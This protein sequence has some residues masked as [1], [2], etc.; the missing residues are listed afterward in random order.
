MEFFADK[1]GEDDYSLIR[2]K[3]KF[4]PKKNRNNHLE[5]YIDNISKFP[6]QANQ[7]V[8]QNISKAEKLALKRLQDD[9]SIIIKQADKGGAIVIMDSDYYR[10]L[11][12]DQLSDTSFYSE[13]PENID[14]RIMRRLNNLV[15]RYEHSLTEKEAD[16]LVNFSHKTSNF[17]GL[18]KI[19]KS[20]QIQSAVNLQGTEYIK[21]NPP[22]DLKL[23]P[24]IAG[25]VCPTHR[26]SN[27]ID[28]VLKPLCAYV[29]SFI[30]DDIDFLS[31]VPDRTDPNSLL[32]SYD[33]T[34]L[35]TNIP[36]DLGIEAIKFWIEK[37][38]EAVSDRFDNDFIL[39]SVRFILENN[40]FFF[41]G[42]NYLQIKGTAMGTK[43]APTYATLVMGYLEQKLY[44]TMEQKYGIQ[45]TRDFEK[46]WKRFLDDCFIIWT[47]GN[48]LL[49]ELTEM[50]NNLHPSI[51]FT[52]EVS[53][54]TL[55]FLDISVQLKDEKL[56]TDI[57]Y[58][59]TD[60]HQY[61][62]FKS[63]HPSHTKRNIPYCLARK[64]CTVIEDPILRDE[65]LEELSQFLLKQKYPQNI[66]QH[67]IERAKQ[68]PIESLR[69]TR[70]RAP[71]S[72][73]NDDIIPF[74]VTHNPCNPNIFNIAKANLPILTQSEKLKD[75]ITPNTLIQ[76]KRQP[77][78]LK[79]L[80]TKARFD[81]QGDDKTVVSPCKD[82]RCGTCKYIHSGHE[83]T[84]KDG[85]KI[86]T[87]ANMDCKS[88][89]LIYCIKCPNCK[90]IYIG[91]TGN[92]L[93]ERMRVHRQQV[94]DAAYRQIPLS[95]HIETCGG[96]NF[97]IFP[98]YK[99]KS[100]RDTL[101]DLKER[102]F[103]RKFKPIL[104]GR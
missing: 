6:L 15:S 91:Q 5:Q 24:I 22:T 48:D 59:N 60:T 8:R 39:E 38:R 102:N 40:S 64:I 85:T 79:R 37:H 69:T 3:S 89:N 14:S 100:Q 75:L 94:R 90:E 32:V 103:I 76:S 27:L 87:N 12:E 10:G 74:V 65:R 81:P 99:M 83:I 9:K 80:L 53:N 33:V 36:H 30:R 26:L 49:S 47:H 62:N 20:A 34:S 70:N 93:S 61:L 18:P 58:K 51:K 63:C 95:A 13:I 17:Y 57:Y 7:N 44:R 73:N 77:P 56:T 54:T 21:V 29:P 67:G 23:R 46:S 43:F 72:A 42:K 16:A 84:S 55:P 88:T 4:T 41:G 25:P 1:E 19:H 98:F 50:L 11:A 97:L 31:H 45:F 52:Q 28:M 2:N 92:A 104:N 82:N 101:R 68:I 71:T 86:Y 78:N 66:I 96:G 35:Y